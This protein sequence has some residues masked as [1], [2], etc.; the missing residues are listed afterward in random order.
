ML[1]QLVMAAMSTLPCLRSTSVFGRVPLSVTIDVG[2]ALVLLVEAI[3]RHRLVE[4]A[5]EFAPSDRAARCGPAGA[6]GPATLGVTSAR[7]S[8]RSAL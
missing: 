1:V 5:E 8:S 7:S 6:S 2:V 3:F 4:R